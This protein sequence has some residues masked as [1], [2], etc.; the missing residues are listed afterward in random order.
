MQKLDF[1]LAKKIQNSE[2]AATTLEMRLKQDEF[3]LFQTQNQNPDTFLF[4]FSEER[5]RKRVQ[6]HSFGIYESA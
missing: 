4:L 5:T 2:K 3:H 6:I 1:F